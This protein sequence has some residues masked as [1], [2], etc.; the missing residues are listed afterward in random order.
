MN[1]I[2]LL[3]NWDAN[4]HADR[5]SLSLEHYNFRLLNNRYVFQSPFLQG[6]TLHIIKCIHWHIHK[7]KS[8]ETEMEFVYLWHTHISKSKC[9]FID[10]LPM[11]SMELAIK[12]V[13]YYIFII[14]Y[15][16]H[17]NNLQLVILHTYH[18]VGPLDDC[19]AKMIGVFRFLNS[20]SRHSECQR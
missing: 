13:Y 3:G 19:H 12:F 5:V 9:K 8:G 6:S 18:S 10:I 2:I 16:Y 15:A 11:N 4:S 14:S 1:N 7:T 20:V 17:T